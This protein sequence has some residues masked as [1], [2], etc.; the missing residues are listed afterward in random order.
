MDISI[1]YGSFF[2]LILALLVQPLLEDRAQGFLLRLISNFW[3]RKKGSIA[4]DWCSIM[5]LSDAELE[6]SNEITNI[7]LTQVGK[8]VSGVFTWNGRS[9]RIL[10][11]R[12][13]SHYL[14][15]TYE[16]IVGGNTFEGSFQLKVLP[17]E[18]VMQGKWLGFDTSGQILEGKWEWR[19]Q[20]YG[21]YA[22]DIDESNNK[23][24]NQFK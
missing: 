23:P 8:R 22:F 2:G 10:A 20:E 21:S 9:Y 13:V 3:I 12:N 4:G 11:K 14:T 7:K 18:N 5:T 17:N 6:R 15:G 16:D 1:L 24:N 19:R